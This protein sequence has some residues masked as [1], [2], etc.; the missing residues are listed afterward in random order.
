[1]LCFAGSPRK[2]YSRSS[3]ITSGEPFPSMHTMPTPAARK[4]KDPD[5]NRNY[6]TYSV[7][8]LLL[9]SIAGANLRYNIKI[10]VCYGAIMVVTLSW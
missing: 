2:A 9:P 10:P 7:S 5:K 1:M 6:H 4:D 8:C 3:S